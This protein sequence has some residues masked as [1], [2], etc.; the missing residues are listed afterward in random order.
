M[1]KTAFLEQLFDPKTIKIIRL[2]MEDN[3]KEYYLQEI[4]KEVKVPVASVFRIVNRMV[5]LD[6]VELVKIKR[7]KL[8]RLA[9]NEKV[10]FL[11]SFLKEGKQIV[12]FFVDHVRKL[13]N[14][15]SII[16]HGKEM[17][18]RANVL[19]LGENVDQGEVKQICGD[20]LS[21]YKFTV[22]TLVLSKEQ[23]VQMTR[24]GLYSGE[25]RSLWRRQ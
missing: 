3:E 2:F 22:S 4:A 17:K 21:K 23:F 15:E 8:Y 24:M 19:I 11:E 1:E 6:I 18:D 14:V 7:F 9:Q 5:S 10:K 13:D 12:E 25:K 20:I 16:L